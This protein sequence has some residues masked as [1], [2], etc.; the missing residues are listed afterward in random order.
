MT[1]AKLQTRDH[2]T[3]GV[4]RRRK[5][6]GLT[7]LAVPVTVFAL[8]AVAEGVGLEPGWWGHL[9]QL[10][11]AVLVAVGAWVRPRIGGPVLILAGTVFTVIVLLGDGEFAAKLAPIAIVFAPLIVAGVFF[12]LAGKTTTLAKRTSRTTPEAG[13]PP[14]S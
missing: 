4:A 7:F 2:D 3:P 8:F 6:I 14:T 1:A 13:E 9:I 11:A 12:T 5:L 10:A